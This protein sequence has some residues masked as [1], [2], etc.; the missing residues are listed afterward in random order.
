VIFLSVIV[1]A[2]LDCATSEEYTA[3]PQ[4]ADYLNGGFFANMFSKQHQSDG[5]LSVDQLEQEYFKLP[6]ISVTRL[7]PALVEIS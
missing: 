6:Q 1:G 4:A 7:Y 2:Q 3:S 5:N